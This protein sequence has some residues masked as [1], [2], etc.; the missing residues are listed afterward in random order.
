MATTP[1]TLGGLIRAKRKEARLSQVEVAQA[2]GISHIDISRYERG[3]RSPSFDRLRL[4]A[5]V[6]GLDIGELA[7]AA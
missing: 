6:I 1:N 5:A 4:I 3:H 2:T 7:V